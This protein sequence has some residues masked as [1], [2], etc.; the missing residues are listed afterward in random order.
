MKPTD[1]LKAAIEDLRKFQAELRHPDYRLAT[2]VRELLAA[3][4]EAVSEDE[5]CGCK[6]SGGSITRCPHGNLISGGSK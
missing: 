6:L 1:R 5:T 4:D 3:Y 2:K